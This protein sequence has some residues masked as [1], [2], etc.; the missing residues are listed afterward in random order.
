MILPEPVDE[1]DLSSLIVLM[2][3]ACAILVKEKDAVDLKPA[4]R[5]DIV[6]SESADSVV[7]DSVLDDVVDTS[8]NVCRGVYDDGASTV[9]KNVDVGIASVADSAKL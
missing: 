7:R 4:G 2:T 8:A 1:D 3:S 5:S 6:D 9:T